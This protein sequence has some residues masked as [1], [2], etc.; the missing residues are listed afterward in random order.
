MAKIVTVENKF[1]GLLRERIAL[2]GLTSNA[3]SMPELVAGLAQQLSTEAHRG[4][5]RG[6]CSA[7]NQAFQ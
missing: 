1:F 7:I 4:A 6:R 3:A 2:A 5:V